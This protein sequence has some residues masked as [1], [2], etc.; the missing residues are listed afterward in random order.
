[1]QTQIGEMAEGFLFK[2]CGC[3]LKWFLLSMCPNKVGDL[4]STPPAWKVSRE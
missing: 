4:L 2:A 3:I 1:M